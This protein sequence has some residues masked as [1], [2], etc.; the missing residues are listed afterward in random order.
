MPTLLPTIEKL[1]KEARELRA[2]DKTI[3]NHTT[4][5]HIIARRHGHKNWAT[6]LSQVE[7]ETAILKF[8]QPDFKNPTIAPNLG[9]ELNLLSPKEKEAEIIRANDLKRKVSNLTRRKGLVMKG[10]SCD[11][12]KAIYDEMARFEKHTTNHYAF[13]F[14]YEKY[15]MIC[16]YFGE[17][18]LALRYA[19]ASLLL[20]RACNDIE[21]VLDAY[22][23]LSFLAVVVNDFRTALRYYKIRLQNDHH[24]PTIGE[25]EFL[26]LLEE[27]VADTEDPR[28]PSIDMKED[29]GYPFKF[30]V[31]FGTDEEARKKELTTRKI[32][33]RLRRGEKEVYYID[34]IDD[35]YEKRKRGEMGKLSEIERLST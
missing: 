15:S 23:Q 18:K 13:R 5:L 10:E 11:E 8:P 2:S 16:I 20:N 1:K 4:A 19:R 6:L 30:E 32:S 26:D 17:F 34:N 31:L 3:K 27:R 22:Q 25:T 7:K 35:M 9:D 12:G 29:V 24:S 21:G 28:R 33:N 14:L